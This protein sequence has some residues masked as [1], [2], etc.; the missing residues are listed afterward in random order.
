MHLT[1]QLQTKLIYH[2]SN[3]KRKIMFSSSWLYLYGLFNFFYFDREEFHMEINF[4][5]VNLVQLNIFR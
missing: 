3:P 1:R 5:F 2:K 4:F